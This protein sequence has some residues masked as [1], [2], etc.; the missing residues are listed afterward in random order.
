MT[1]DAMAGPRL[2]AG[3]DGWAT[4][5]YDATPGPL[6]RD[7]W[8]EMAYDAIAGPTRWLGNDGL[9]EMAGPQ[10]LGRN[11]W[12]LMAV[13][14]WLGHYNEIAGPRLLGRDGLRR[15]GWAIMTLWLGRRDGLADIDGP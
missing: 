7:G 8:T 15:Y 9:A 10:R 14:R 3:R 1:Y 13:P 11:G 12:A 6:R 2:L 5:A 4:M